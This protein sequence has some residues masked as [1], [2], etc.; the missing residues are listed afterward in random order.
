M[1]TNSNTED[2]F[3]SAKRLDA[4]RK[5]ILAVCFTKCCALLL[6]KP[7]YMFSQKNKYVVF[8]Q[9]YCLTPERYC[10]F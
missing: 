2:E 4:V 3:Y 5:I 8:L 6:N 7:P 9:H 1:L 10:L